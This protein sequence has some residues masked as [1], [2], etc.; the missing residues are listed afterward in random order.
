MSNQHFLTEA[1]IKVVDS[2]TATLNQINQSF[3]QLGVGVDAQTKKMQSQSAAMKTLGVTAGVAGAAIL[4]A[5]GLSVT[6]A[7][8]QARVNKQLDAVIKSTGSA[9]GV[10]AEEIRKM[11]S[12]LQ[13]VTNYGDET[14]IGGQNL[15]LTFK[16]IGKDIFPQAT[17][18]MLNMSAAMGTD[19]KSSAIQLGKALND[20]VEGMN[21]LRRV[22]VSFTDQQRDMV[23]TLVQSGKSLEAQKLILVELESQFGN[24]ARAVAEPMQILKN[25]LGDISEELGTAL[26]PMVREFSS[27]IIPIAKGVTD[28]IAKN[29]ALVTVIAQTVVILGVVLTVVAAVTAAF[30]AYGAIATALMGILGGLAPVLGATAVGMSAMIAPIG[31]VIAAVAA[32]VVAF[33]SY[34]AHVED[35]YKAIEA[36]SSEN[37]KKLQG[38]TQSWNDTVIATTGLEQKYAIMRGQSA[39]HLSESVRLSEALIQQYRLQGT[40]AAI[41]NL[42]TQVAFHQKAA[43]D[44]LSAAKDFATNNEAVAEKV[45][46]QYEKI[47][48]A[49]K[50]MSKAVGGS[51]K[52]AKDKMDEV[53]K[54]V[55]DLEKTYDKSIQ[56]INQKLLIL[57]A[58]HK[59]AME[60]L[61]RDLSNV[62]TSMQKLS[63]QYVKATGELVDAH[64]K[65][66]SDLNEDKGDAVIETYN[67]LVEAQQK[68]KDLQAKPDALRAEQVVTIIENRQDKG[69]T[70]SARDKQSFNVSGDGESQINEILKMRKEQEGLTKVLQAN[71]NLTEQQ[72]ASLKNT[73]GE[74]QLANIKKIVDA[75]KDLAKASDFS[76]LTELQRQFAGFSETAT[77]EAN[78]FSKAQT[79]KNQNYTEEVFGLRKTKKELEDKMKMEK[80]VYDGTRT[81]LVKTKKQMQDFQEVYT[82]SLQDLDSVTK[83]TVGNMKTKLQ[84]LKETISG[85][86]ALI[87]AKS[88]ITGGVSITSRA[89]MRGVARSANGNVFTQPSLT[90]IAEDGQAE[91]VVPLPDGRRIP[92]MMQGNQQQ[93][94]SNITVNLGGV[95]IKNDMDMRTVIGAIV[96][97]I[98]NQQLKA[99]S[100]PR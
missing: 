1:E 14:I 68:L 41:S 2:A 6:A 37:L 71:Y 92:V 33:Q 21:A 3:S 67:R 38:N 97:A 43:G 31:L 4:G 96:T 80:T 56:E 13:A 49:S 44:A 12:S 57:K 20:P 86:E 52:D 22:G 91:A 54:A 18:A 73:Y 59:V 66:M 26:L 19:L 53:K 81:E 58:N 77:E 62:G 45:K 85:I 16:N 99:R 78:S 70:L 65:A 95:E 76:N 9:A 100:N 34:R 29:Q 79:E 25:Q 8:E 28:W 63:S 55:Q 84:E 30:F 32:V 69:D 60:A 72:A 11:A 50:G 98:D 39:F 64:K 83:E 36:S 27:A 24:V 17:E 35:T 23:K 46:G 10:T 82:K 87:K 94:A 42:Q 93:Q 48:A 75:N 88:E 40:D 51:S 7:L 74:A 15:L 90:T 5:A 89:Q 61:Q 47:G